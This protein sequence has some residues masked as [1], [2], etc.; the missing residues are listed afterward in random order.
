MMPSRAFTVSTPNNLAFITCEN[1]VLIGAFFLSLRVGIP[2]DMSFRF[3]E[4]SFKCL[5]HIQIGA[6]F[7]PISVDE[8]RDYG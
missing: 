8:E 6:E 7:L 2:D 3:E 4:S 5:N 1:T